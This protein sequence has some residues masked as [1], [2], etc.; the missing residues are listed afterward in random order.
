[1]RSFKPESCL[2]GGLK[3]DD[4][5]PAVAGWQHPSQSRRPY[6]RWRNGDRSM[7]TRI[8]LRLFFVA[9]LAVPL[10]TFALGVG[11]LE[12]RSSLNQAFEAEIPLIV[13]NPIELTGLTV[14]IPR[15]Q[16]FDHIGVERLTLFSKLRFSVRASP[17]GPNT[18][19]VTSLEPIREPNFNL[20]LELTWPRGRLI[21]E[22]PVQLDPE[23]Y[24]DRHPP[25]LPPPPVVVTP[26]VAVVPPPVKTVPVVPALPPAPPISFEGAS[27][28]GPVKPGETL[29]A[30]ARRVRSS[31]T[32]TAPQMMAILVAGNPEAFVNG[33]PNTLRA[34][35]TLKV[36]N[37][38][39]LGISDTPAPSSL[40]TPE[41]A[42]VSP[43]PPVP[44]AFT[45]PP[46]TPPLP[47]APSV[48]EPAIS[49]PP[50]VIATAP[51]PPA[52]EIG[53]APSPVLSPTG[54]PQEIVP[55]ASIPQPTTAPTTPAAPEPE[56][57]TPPPPVAISPQ[58]APPPTATVKPL[59]PTPVADSEASWMDN[60]V[61][62]PILNFFDD[63]R[64]G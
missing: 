33:N 3:R 34:G 37:P 14:R 54:Q 8:L 61:V 18:I 27:F 43:P 15:Q 26:P 58:P 56:P 40:T 9:G 41:L 4:H 46:T 25:P 53:S 59:V 16:D 51:I 5:Q 7:L 62:Y 23:L 35:A 57:V 42:A 11:P 52:P 45:E 29:A 39:A 44:P 32:I 19:R 63:L 22:F 13:S 48:T 21:R 30:I 24:A 60:P 2:T 28:Y 50:A 1:M 38:K 55:Q 49:L 20:L 6:I 12:V 36:P 17:G 64:M 10:C 47:A 31:P